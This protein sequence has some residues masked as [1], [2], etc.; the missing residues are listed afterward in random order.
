MSANR[1]APAKTKA[2]AKGAGKGGPA[3]AYSWPPFEPGNDVSIRHGAYAAL[4]LRPRAEEIAVRLREAM[5]DTFEDKFTPALETASIALARIER[6]AG[7]LFDLDEP[8]IEERFSRL[9][10]RLKGWVRLALQNLEALG[11]TPKVGVI[12][13][14]VNVQ[15]AAITVEQDAAAQARLFA[16]LADIGLVRRDVVDVE[17]T[18]LRE[19]EAG[20]PP[21][22]R[23][24]PA[25]SRDPV[26]TSPSPSQGRS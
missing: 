11:L 19:L 20:V 5:G 15:V 9:D 8:E 4:H 16:K 2:P 6:A 17:A 22:E 21:E 13:G 25:S 3:R 1:K 14:S 18:E 24:N 12:A 10:D 23:R 26:R 7:F